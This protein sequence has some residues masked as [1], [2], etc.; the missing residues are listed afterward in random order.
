MGNITKK[1]PVEKL[2]NI[3][4][5]ILDRD[6]TINKTKP[7]NPN[8]PKDTGYILNAK[9]FEFIDKACEGLAV[10]SK[11]NI[12]IHIFTQQSGIAKGCLS[13]NELADI[14]NYM[15]KYLLENFAVK[16]GEITYC[17]HTKI[18]GVYNCDCAKLAPNE[19]PVNYRGQIGKIIDITKL[20]P[21]QILVIG[22]SVRDIP[23]QEFIDNGMMFIG[24]RNSQKPQEADKISSMGYPV[25]QN[26]LDIALV[27]SQ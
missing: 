18:N 17:P 25:A 3:T 12:A 22:D 26:I 15:K 24:V 8:N 5:V 10:F 16:I 27:T 20:K 2:K 14:H 11:N 7:A 19:N 9:Q 23:P 4:A 13:K 1:Y 6:G 21:A